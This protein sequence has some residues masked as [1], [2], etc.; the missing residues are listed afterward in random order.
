M[1]KLLVIVGCIVILILGLFVIVIV[2]SKPQFEESIINTKGNPYP[3]VFKVSF[4][5]TCNIGEENCLCV[6]DYLQKNYSY[7]EFLKDGEKGDPALREAAAY[8]K[9]RLE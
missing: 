3:D 9:K 4:L 7:N 6:F 5:K 1:K 8:C 2:R